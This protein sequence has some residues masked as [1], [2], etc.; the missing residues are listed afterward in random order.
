MNRAVQVFDRLLI[1]LVLA[2]LIFIVGWRFPI[3]Y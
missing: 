3:A 1:A 2:F